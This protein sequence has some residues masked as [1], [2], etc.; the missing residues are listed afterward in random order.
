MGEN[1]GIDLEHWIYGVSPGKGY[2]TKAESRALNAALYTRA[3]ANLYTP[4]RLMKGDEAK[5]RLDVRMIHPA[6]ATDEVLVSLLSLGE[7]DEYT[8]PT[9]QNHTVIIPTPMLKDGRLSFEHVEAA[10]QIFDRH[11]PRASGRIDPIRVQPM[12]RGHGHEPV[13]VGIRKMMTRA[14]LETL[15]SRLLTEPES[16]V[17]ILCRDSSDQFRNLLLYRIVELILASGDIPLFP[18]ISDAPTLTALNHFRV[19]IS[20]RGVRADHTWSLLDATINTP[21]LPRYEGKT[22]LYTRIAE[23]FAAL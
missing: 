7:P 12:D 13:A 8:R 10:V 2:G 14:A 9:I 18:A 3:L 4:V 17:L 22:P 19:A 15:A 6:P 5:V 23:A 16:R 1:S 21:A 11:Y 20:A